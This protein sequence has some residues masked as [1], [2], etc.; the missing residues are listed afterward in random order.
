MVWLEADILTSVVIKGNSQLWIRL[1]VAASRWKQS[2]KITFPWGTASLQ[3]RPSA[4]R[5][6]GPVMT[7]G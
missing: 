3:P 7:T 6:R 5:R 2:D 4:K 1:W